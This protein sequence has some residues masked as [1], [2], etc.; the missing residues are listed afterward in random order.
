MADGAS[1]VNS[2]REFRLLVL[3]GDGIG[4][5]IVEQTLRVVD[6]FGGYLGVRFAIEAAAAGGVSIEECGAPISD[7]VMDRARQADAILFGAVGGPDW[8]DLPR[9][10]RPEVAILRLRKELDL[11]ANLRPAINFPEIVGASSLRADVVGAID[12]MIVRECTSGVYF[13]EPRGISVDN[14]GRRRAVDTQAYSETEIERVCRAAFGI[15]RGR[16]G[17]LC[18]VDKANVMETG[19]L[20]RAVVTE[21]GR[22][23]PDVELTH[24]YADNCAMQ[25]LRDPRQFD[26]IVADNLFGDILSDEAA[27][28]S[29]SLGLLPSATLQMSGDARSTNALYEPIHGSAPDIAGRGIANP[30]ASILSFGMCLTHSLDAPAAS[31][32]LVRSIRLVLARGVRTADIA[33]AG[34]RSVPGAAMT[35]AVLAALD[36]L[37]VDLQQA[38]QS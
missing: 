30:L 23:Y 18:S 20:W 4:P 31:D 5:E 7:A 33:S 19:Q 22:D 34:E 6:W 15:A 1:D 9:A 28:L 21:V 2:G 24:M 13:G 29:G 3:P 38:L 17:R 27:A 16:G 10:H 14:N 35:D 12:I 11:F 37:A 26:V 36:E 32:L 25:L 8:D